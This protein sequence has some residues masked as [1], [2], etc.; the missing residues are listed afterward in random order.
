MFQLGSDIKIFPSLPD[1]NRNSIINQ[2]AQ[3][4][5]FYCSEVLK[6]IVDSL[7]SNPNIISMKYRSSEHNGSERI[8]KKQALVN[9]FLQ[10]TGLQ[11]QLEYL[12]DSKDE[13]TKQRVDIALKIGNKMVYIDFNGAPH[14]TNSHNYYQVDDQQKLELKLKVD[15]EK[16][17]RIRQHIRPRFNEN[18]ACYIIIEMPEEINPKKLKQFAW[19]YFKYC[20]PDA[21]IESKMPKGLWS[22]YQ[23]WLKEYNEFTQ[24][25]LLENACVQLRNIISLFEENN[26]VIMQ[27]VEK[28]IPLRIYNG[29]SFNQSRSSTNPI[30]CEPVEKSFRLDNAVMIRN[31]PPASDFKNYIELKY[32]GLPLSYILQTDPSFLQG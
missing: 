14:F 4:R 18:S 28:E 21:K 22:I 16:Q 24:R 6:E 27:Y 17:N 25:A 20:Y 10:C 31:E 2:A 32:Q 5:F 8:S 11:T 13:A 9:Q 29:V 30:V 23:A 19:E 7:L 26:P 15:F 3:C 12:V 1:Q